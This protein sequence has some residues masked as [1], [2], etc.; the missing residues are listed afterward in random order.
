MTFDYIRYQSDDEQPTL[1]I[2]G[3]WTLQNLSR[4]KQSLSALSVD[5]HPQTTLDANRLE[6][7]DTSGA[8]ALLT[9]LQIQ[10]IDSENT[11]FAN[12][13]SSHQ[14]IIQ[15][16]MLHMPRDAH[17][18]K[19]AALLRSFFC[20]LGDKTLCFIAQS[21]GYISH[22]GQIT[23]T[24]L[25]NFLDLRQFRFKEIIHHFFDICIKSLP[26]IMLLTFLLSIILGY[27]GQKFLQLFG[28]NAY[29]IDSITLSI[30]RNIGVLLVA[31]AVAARSGSTITSAIGI[32]KINE[33][34]AAIQTMGLNPYQLIALPRLI[35]ISLA[36]PCLVLIADVVG[37]LGAA[38][39]T[40]EVLDLNIAQFIFR[41]KL[42]L[43]PHDFA[44][45]LVK[46][47]IF[48]FIIG[49][50][51]TLKGLEVEGKISNVSE[52]TRQA[53]V[54][55]LFLVLMADTFL[56]YYFIHIGFGV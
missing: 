28:A 7:I 49:S 38:L 37:M 4:I 44:V 25:Y 53:V 1:I 48:G 3:Q 18:D 19:P 29:T 10:G 50:V 35:A 23:L 47:P 39:F 36:L 11:Q 17:D 27:Q 34:V 31:I 55:S 5:K 56:S 51:C 14:K 32:M 24:F 52:N 20:F 40:I 13:K 21:R 16:V 30:L 12:I 46:A 6:S 54:Q 43:A 42:A 33:E 45:G 26:L 15:M 41:L 22:L 9:Y 2:S 8:L